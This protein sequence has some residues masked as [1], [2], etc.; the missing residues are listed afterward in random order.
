MLYLFN[1]QKTET[2]PVFL[3]E[4]AK[5]RPEARIVEIEIDQAVAKT[6]RNG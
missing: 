1:L 4:S 3:I 2:L 5:L 6:R